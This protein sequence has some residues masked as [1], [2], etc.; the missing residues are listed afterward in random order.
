MEAG[1]GGPDYVAFGAFFPT[2][3]QGAENQADIELLAGGGDDGS[4]VVAIGGI[5]VTNAQR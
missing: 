5:T 2:A 4:A 3:N 1:R